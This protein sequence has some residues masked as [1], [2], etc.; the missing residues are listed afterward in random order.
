MRKTKKFPIAITRLIN[1]INEL[2]PQVNSCNDYAGSYAGST[3]YSYIILDNEI[4][5]KNNFVY[6]DTANFSDNYPFEKRYNVNNIECDIKG[7]PALKYD[8][9]L[10]IKAFKQCIKNN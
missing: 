8:L 9:R 2:L 6:I 3:Y 5:V 7:L 10:I 1:E 4:R